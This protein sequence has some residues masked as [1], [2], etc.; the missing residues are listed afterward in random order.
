MSKYGSVTFKEV[1]MPYH[2]ILQRNF[3]CWKIKKKRG[4]ERIEKLINMISVCQVTSTSTY[5]KLAVLDFFY[6]NL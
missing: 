2:T 3:F 4:T 5:K 6:I 1:S